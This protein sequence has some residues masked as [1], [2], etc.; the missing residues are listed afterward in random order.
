MPDLTAT[1]SQPAAE[2]ERAGSGTTPAVSVAGLNKRFRLPHEQYHTLKQ[3][4]IHP[5]ASRNFDELNALKDVNFEVPEGEFF[6]I[7][8]RNGSGKRRC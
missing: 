7:V 4:A 3:R 2:R 8:G 6:G 1:A 5:F